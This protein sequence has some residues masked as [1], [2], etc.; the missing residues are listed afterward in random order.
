[1]NCHDY[2]ITG[3][4]KIRFVS[5]SFFT[6]N[7]PTE[8]QGLRRYRMSTETYPTQI[9]CLHRYIHN[10]AIDP[11][12]KICTWHLLDIRIL[13]TTSG[14]F[15]RR[16]IYLIAI[17][18]RKFNRIYKKNYDLYITR[19]IRWFMTDSVFTLWFSIPL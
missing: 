9:Q 4:Y 6:L 16:I 12:S 11:N 15:Q 19:N 7:E 1:M 8:M 3:N 18:K 2:E 14:Y 13:N 10:R 17:G 5:P